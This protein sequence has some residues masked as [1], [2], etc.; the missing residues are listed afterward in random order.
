MAT[1]R[2]LS[3]SKTKVEPI[4]IADLLVRAANEHP[5]SGLR[6]VSAEAP[7]EIAFLSYPDLLSEARQILGGL[8]KRESRPSAK[9]ALLLERPREFIPTFW[10]CVLGGYIPCP[11]APIRSDADRW[12][13]HLE[14]VDT[15]LDKPLFVSSG[16]ALRELPAFADAADFAD[17]VGHAPEQWIHEAKLS[18]PAILML[19]S[20]ST[21]NSKAVEL[22]HSNLMASMRGRCERQQLTGE[23]ITF[24]W[25]AFDHVAALLESHMLALFAGATQLHAEPATILSD[26]LRFLRL[27]DQQRVSLA[28]AP[29][30][31]LGQINAELQ[32]GLATA[33]KAALSLDL[34]SL[35]RI[36]TGGEAN[37][38]ET[39]RRFLDLLSPHGLARNVLWPAFGMTET[40]AASIYSSEFPDF[41]VD[42]EFAAVGLPINGMEIRIV[43]DAGRACSAEQAGELQV[44]GPIIFGRYYNNEEATKSAFTSD[45]WFRTGD[46]GRLENGMLCLIARNKD[47]IIVN[48]VNYYSHELETKL[49]QLEGIQRSFVAA[50]PTRPKGADTEQLVVTFA[51]TVPASDEAA[52]YQLLVAV[53]NTAIML[54]GFRPAV[55]LPLPVDAFPKT[56][57]GKI[58]RTLMRKRF[59]AGELDEFRTN[60]T[61]IVSRQI[62]PYSPPA[63]D[64]ENAIA[65]VFAEILRVDQASVSATASFFDL[66]GTSLDIIRFTKMLERRFWLKA[67]LP[68]V[69]GN[70]SVRE[71]ARAISS[72]MQQRVSEYDAIVPL[73]TTGKK[74]PLFCVHPGN[75]EVFI[76]VN[77]AKYFLNDRPFYALRPR[78]FTEGEECFKSMDEMVSTYVAAIRK[79]QPQGPY[80][81]A[82][83]S[84]GC[85]IAFQVAKRLETEGDSVG[86][87]GVIDAPPRCQTIELEF[88]MATGLA[89]VTD[90]ITLEQ[91]EALNKELRPEL[92]S[93]EVCEYVLKFAS[94]KRLQQL[95]LDLKKFSRWARVAHEM[96]VLLFKNVTSG[97][98]SS[99]TA[100]RSEGIPARYTSAGWSRESWGRELDRWAQFTPEYRYIDVPGD[101]H[102]LMAPKHV[103]TFQAVLR[104]EI[105]RAMDSHS[106]GAGE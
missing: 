86:F 45:G 72:G 95:D 27:I 25:I 76:L 82:G 80:A 16:E 104:G 68:I 63:G 87:F 34:S 89:M 1:P 65:S 53:R 92:P 6:V 85:E 99:I 32:A 13:K 43:D 105:D 71:L 30:F 88:N 59:E 22:T 51:T 73:Q 40:C 35:R 91:Y 62:G 100:F 33:G 44:R 31:L 17:L 83:Y 8:R 28:F 74:S 93:N 9:I 97:A 49:E 14:H 106:K 5:E 52:L 79:R 67:G 18:D 42:H 96:E 94:Q 11:L 20:G 75:G 37:V 7:D 41:D 101:H 60:I 81:I 46:V 84:L 64:L 23:D 102:L 47:S 61:D 2:P 77:L 10:A 55:V 4:V 3:S 36:V 69:L 58:Q 66:G 39:G 70:P 48:G 98:V 57:L 38:V 29:N 24:N 15:V 54:W 103:A 21:G 56:S 26:P 12:S 78:G 50:F 90:L 19:T